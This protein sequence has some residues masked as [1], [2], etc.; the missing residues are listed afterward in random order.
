M[1]LLELPKGCDYW[2]DKRM[3]DMINGTDSHTHEFDGCMYGLKSKYTKIGTPIKKPWRIISWGVSFKKLH[4]RCDG[5]HAHGPCAG[6]ETRITQLYTEQI[7]KI[8]LK[9]VKNQMLLNNAYGIKRNLKPKMTSVCQALS[10]IR[11]CQD[12]IH[13]DDQVQRGFQFLHFLHC[14]SFRLKVK[15]WTPGLRPAPL[16]DPDSYWTVILASSAMA[17]STA[18]M[19]ENEMKTLTGAKATTRTLT[20]LDT[21]RK[22]GVANQLPAKFTLSHEENGPISD[23]AVDKWLSSVKIPVIVVASL[24]FA[25][26]RRNP[27]NVTH[28]LQLL[29]RTL[30]ECTLRSEVDM[31]AETYIGTASRMMKVF[32]S[33]HREGIEKQNFDLLCSPECAIHAEDLQSGTPKL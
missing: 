28:A 2:R 23:T 19:T 7:V 4:E 18:N 30:R 9:G 31:N 6:R 8:V 14:G 33:K 11:I 10:C 22:R 27:A 1:A 12:H 16:P 20:M 3:T 29:A 24:T 25:S 21:L 13:H 32:V 5:S 17:S 15:E 26:R